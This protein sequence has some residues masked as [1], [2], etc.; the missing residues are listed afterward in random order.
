[1]NTNSNESRLDIARE[2]LLAA[3]PG[4]LENL[5]QDLDVI[6]RASGE[7]LDSALVESI[8]A[9]Y[10]SAVLNE[11]ETSPQVQ[12]LYNDLK[13]YQAEYYSSKGVI[14]SLAVTQ[15]GDA[16]LVQTYAQ[17]IDEG[18]CQACSWTGQWTISSSGEVSGTLKIRAFVHEEGSLQYHSSREFGPS[19]PNNVTQQICEWE[20]EAMDGIGEQYNSMN[21]NLKSLRRVMPITRTKMDWNLT[22]HRMVKLLGDSKK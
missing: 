14:S 7:T 19:S 17:R 5:V 8:R 13:S 15:Q 20:Q 2:M 16:T 21:N 9:E 11:T 4:Q 1:M 12:Q 6:F 3:P 22:G 10:G 18:N